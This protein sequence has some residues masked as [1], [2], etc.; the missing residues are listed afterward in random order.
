MNFFKT[1]LATAALALA[2]GGAQAARLALV[3]S[4]VSGSLLTRVEAVS[5]EFTVA[6]GAMEDLSGLS[7]A[8]AFGSDSQAVTLA[9]SGLSFTNDW[10]RMAALDTSTAVT[11]FSATSSSSLT[12]ANAADVLEQGSVGLGAELLVA[13][14]GEAA[15]T[16]VTVRLQLSASSL[17]SSSDA[18]ATDTP[19]FNLL[20]QDAAFNTLASYNGLALNGSDVLDVSFASAVGEHLSMS[21]SLLNALSAQPLGL[22]GVQTIDSSALLDGTLTVTAVPEPQ[23]LLLMLAGLGLVGAAARRRR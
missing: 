4:T 1:V 18:S 5:G 21:L 13:S 14:D 11:S 7:A 8:L 2:A 19:A 6:S 22:A 17:F 12:V 3:E 9:S 15:G 10:V 23:T 16:A 20:V